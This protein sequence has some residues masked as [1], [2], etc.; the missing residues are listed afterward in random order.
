MEKVSRV[1][2]FGVVVATFTAGCVSPP[3]R[4]THAATQRRPVRIVHMGSPS[5][6]SVVYAVTPSNRVRV[7]SQ[8]AALGKKERVTWQDVDRIVTHFAGQHR[9]KKS[10]VYAIM[11][12]TSNFNLKY[13]SVAGAEGLMSLMPH[14]VRVLGV[15]DP[16]NPVQNIAGG[17]L[18]LRRMLNEF[19]NNGT[20]ALA[21]YNA[22]PGA[23]RKHKGVPPYRETQEFIRRVKGYA[24]LY[25]ST[26]PWEAPPDEPRQKAV[27]AHRSRSHWANGGR[28]IHSLARAYADRYNLDPALVLAVIRVESNFNAGAVSPAGARGLMQLMPGTARVLGV[29]DS[30]DPEQNIAG[31]TKYLAQQVAEFGNDARLVLAAYHAGPANVRKYR[32]VPPFRTTQE[33]V[34]TVLLYRRHYSQK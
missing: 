21:A 11:K 1:V 2:V 17:T 10:Y 28:D 7:P 22:G 5:R 15:A 25:E 18:Y 27:V 26:L 34:E 24:Q 6:R 4:N 20:L 13:R 9:I 8:L 33:Y 16:Y 23:V 31:G 12:T 32:G 19:G 3:V 30:F 14:T 29:R